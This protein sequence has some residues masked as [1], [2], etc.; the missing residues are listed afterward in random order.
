MKNNCRTS[1]VKHILGHRYA[2][3]IKS[4]LDQRGILSKRN[5]PYTKSYIRK[6]I[7][8]HHCSPLITLATTVVMLR[9]IKKQA[10]FSTV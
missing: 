2:G 6:I 8:G 1:Q 10:F 3:V 7:Q 9:T 4:Y 5:R